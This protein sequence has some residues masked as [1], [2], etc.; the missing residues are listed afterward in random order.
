MA[1]DAGIAL[2]LKPVQIENPLNNMVKFANIQNDM[3]N[4]ALHRQKMASE[5]ADA[6][7]L[8]KLSQYLSG[9]GRDESVILGLRGDKEYNQMRQAD[10]AKLQGAEVAGKTA[11]AS[12]ARYKDI[13]SN[14]V[15]NS[16]DARQWLYTMAN[17][18]ATKA[19][20]NQ[21]GSFEELAKRIPD[22]QAG[23]DNW[24]ENNVIGMDK[25]LQNRAVK[26]TTNLGN[27]YEHT[28]SQGRLVGQPMMIGA[29]IK[30]RS[31]IPPAIL[32]G[33][34]NQ[35]ALEQQIKQGNPAGQAPVA[36]QAT[37]LL[38]ASVAQAN[39]QT[40]PPIS[41]LAAN[42]NRQQAELAAV[43][44]KLRADQEQAAAD[45]KAFEF[46]TLVAEVAKLEADGEGN[47]P[48]AQRL[49]ARIAKETYIPPASGE[50][51]EEQLNALYGPDGSVTQGRL[52][53][54][55]VNGRTAKVYA[56]AEITN[57]GTNFNQ[58]EGVAALNRN[59]PFMA[60]QYA[61]EMLPQMLT[62][63]GEAGKKLNFSDNK[64]FG[65]LQAW[66]KGASNDPDF[67]IYM[68]QRMDTLLT[69]TGAMRAVGMSDLAQKAEDEAAPKMMSPRAFDAY[70]QGQYKALEPRLN[71]SRKFTGTKPPAETPNAPTKTV[72]GQTV[73]NW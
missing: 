15:H 27:R 58:L 48:T 43:N 24:K 10:L 60:K 42:V 52:A 20:F 70:I 56:N 59:A 55:K 13:L 54:Y 2:G 11:D 71:L 7:R 68:A 19:I 34:A 8:N 62:N 50:L 33:L 64:Y 31:E 1:I 40:P 25:F 66:Y 5:V 47:S 4:M 21:L 61:I 63:L 51:S 35:D 23:Y 3:A 36:S 30:E 44:T 39:D 46:K 38:N 18:P 9:G 12:M 37:Q 6:E 69:L 22:D 26:Q 67:R 73:K 16:K 41:P 29:T 57:P 28:D 65:E 53:P 45:K 72:T 32:T 49:K 14:Y 17:D